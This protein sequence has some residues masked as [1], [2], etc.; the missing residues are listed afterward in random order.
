[1]IHLIPSTNIGTF[2]WRWHLDL[3]YLRL[4]SKG[5]CWLGGEFLNDIIIVFR[6]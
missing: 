2:L 5:F 6:L 1:M 3:Q 4:G